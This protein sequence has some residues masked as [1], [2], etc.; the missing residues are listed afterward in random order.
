MEN[1]EGSEFRNGIFQ[2]VLKEDGARVLILPPGYFGSVFNYYSSEVIVNKIHTHTHTHTYYFLCIYVC[3]YLFL[4]ILLG[5]HPLLTLVSGALTKAWTE[6]KRGIGTLTVS[7]P[8]CHMGA[9]LHYGHYCR[10]NQSTADAAEGADP[11]MPGRLGLP[12]DYSHSATHFITQASRMCSSPRSCLWQSPPQDDPSG[13]FILALSSG[14]RGV[15]LLPTKAYA[16]GPGLIPVLQPV[17][18]EKRGLTLTHLTGPTAAP[19][20]PLGPC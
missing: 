3:M 8:N 2:S 17:A 1:P 19:R 14:L 12:E 5:L 20:D 6:E 9:A 18:L 4:K 10:V 11:E 16:P 7:A 15:R 13:I